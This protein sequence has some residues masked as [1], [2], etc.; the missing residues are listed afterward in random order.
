VAA[1]EADIVLVVN[2]DDPIRPGLVEAALSVFERRPGVVAVYPDWAWIDRAGEVMRE[3][4]TVDFSIE[5]LIRDFH[6]IPGPGASFRR[7]ALQGA[8]ARNPRYPLTSDYDMWLRLALRGPFARIPEVLATWRQHAGGTSATG[9][10]PALASER[11]ALMRE[12]FARDDLPAP[13]A[14]LRRKAMASAYYFAGLVAIHH[15]EVPGRRYLLRSYLLNPW[16]DADTVPTCRRSLAR[17]GV[18]FA[19]PFSQPALQALQRLG[20]CRDFKLPVFRWRTAIPPNASR[21]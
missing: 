16:Q 13:I 12:F 1:A 15:P 14:A 2:A 20:L 8:D 10:T 7:S 17:S 21:S 3:V 19:R 9:L 4:R 18:I 5:A 11:I 6:C